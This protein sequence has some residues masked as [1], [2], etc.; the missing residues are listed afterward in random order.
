MD[1][2]M[3]VI[4]TAAFWPTLVLEVFLVGL[5]SLCWGIVFI[6]HSWK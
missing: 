5:C 6:K 2:V 1:V 3:I 4:R